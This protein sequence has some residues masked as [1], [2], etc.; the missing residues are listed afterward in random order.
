[1]KILTSLSGDSDTGGIKTTLGQ[2]RLL[3]SLSRSLPTPTPTQASLSHLEGGASIMFL[4]AFRMEWSFL[5]MEQRGENHFLP[6]GQLLS[7]VCPVTP[8]ASGLGALLPF[9]RSQLGVGDPGMEASPEWLRPALL[10]GRKPTFPLGLFPT[11]SLVTGTERVKK[12]GVMVSQLALKKKR[13]AFVAFA[14]P[15]A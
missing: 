3:Q 4:A 1:M 10:W 7:S 13:P 12:V 2:T 5:W 11:F 6:C 15:M 8:T 9:P 14:D